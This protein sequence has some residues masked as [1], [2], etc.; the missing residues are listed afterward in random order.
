M[1]SLLEVLC[2]VDDF[3]QTYH[4]AFAQVQLEADGSRRRHRAGKM[5][6]SEMM[7]RVIHFHQSGYRD[8]K[9]YYV[10]YVQVRLWGEFPYQVSYARFV[11]WLPRLATP[12]AA[13]LATRYGKSTGIT[14]LDSTALRVCKNPRISSHKVFAGYA[15]RGKTS[16][17]WFFGF[18][19]HLAI[20]DRGD[21]LGV[22]LTRANVDDR[23]PVPHL[24]RAVQGKVFADKGY[25]SQDLFRRL[26][27]QGIHLITRLRSNMKN[28]LM[29]YFDRILLRKRVLIETVIDQLK[30][31]SQIEH[32]PHRS[33]I[34]FTVH[35]LAGLLAYTFQPK[36]PSLGLAS[37]PLLIHN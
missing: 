18:K 14:F 4:P 31:V 5:R 29:P 7:T 26:F 10:K 36:K 20:N 25:L 8:F 19:L 9:T 3:C 33:P 24:L 6:L 22:R 17:G 11:Q 27:A 32:S 34:N 35:L 1:E 28:R 37:F 21:L 30:N 15:H 23:R 13:F 16:T 12:L 2:A